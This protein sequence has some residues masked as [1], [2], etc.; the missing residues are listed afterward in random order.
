M[1]RKDAVFAISLATLLFLGSWDQMERLPVLAFYHK[2]FATRGDLLT[3]LIVNVL[4]MAAA[5][6]GTVRIVRSFVDPWVRRACEMTLLLV[7]YIPMRQ[8]ILWIEP[9]EG[10]WQRALG[11]VIL[12]AAAA[13]A[14]PLRRW[15]VKIATRLVIM[16]SP[17][18]PLL[19]VHFLLQQQPA[20]KAWHDRPFARFN[21]SPPQ[22]R[23]VLVIFDSWDRYL[24]F[25][26]RPTSIQLL[27]IDSF[28]NKAIDVQR[29]TSPAIWTRL[30]LPSLL[31]GVPVK[32]AEPKGPD[33]L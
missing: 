25:E 32:A 7:L 20:R 14:A 21:P 11:V 3:A 23:M 4:L 22:R 27:E 29:T 15:P 9:S 24:T 19:L 30:S 12:L 26:A 10:H 1:K 8:V 33:Q 13:T 31:T 6:F 16:L 2:E 17:L 5:I 28:R 18:L